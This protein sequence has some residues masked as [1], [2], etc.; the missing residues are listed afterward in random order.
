MS[1]EYKL[2]CFHLKCTMGLKTR[3]PLG[4]PQKSGHSFKRMTQT[5]GVVYNETHEE[6]KETNLQ[7]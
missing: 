6:K 4:L 3:E 7:H 1:E 5:K 2:H